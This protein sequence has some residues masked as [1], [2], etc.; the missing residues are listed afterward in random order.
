MS[1]KETLWEDSGFDC[2]H[3]GG[4][5]HKRIDRELGHH[6]TTS[7]QCR[8][9]HCRWSIHGALLTIGNLPVCQQADARTSRRPRTAVKPPSPVT[10]AEKLPR[11][12]VTKALNRIIITLAV[13]VGFLFLLRFAGAVLFRFFVP[14]LIVGVIAYLV[15]RMG[16]QQE[17][18]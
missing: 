17:W 8:Q 12:D 1:D 6:K 2:N 4:E 3:C 9:C 16:R 15:F 13:V 18:W 11:I 14:G 7:F 10:I 5:I